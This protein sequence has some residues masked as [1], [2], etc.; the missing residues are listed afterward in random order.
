MKVTIVVNPGHYSGYPSLKKPV[1]FPCR[2][3]LMD[4]ICNPKK[5]AGR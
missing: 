3:R 5:S 2:I 4:Y 1:I